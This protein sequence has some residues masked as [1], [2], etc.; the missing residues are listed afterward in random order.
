MTSIPQCTYCKN[1]KIENG[2]II[3]KKYQNI[4]EQIANG[5]ETCKYFKGKK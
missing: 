1:A 3:C 2:V 4:P 5:I